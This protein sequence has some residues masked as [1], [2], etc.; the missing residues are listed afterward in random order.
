MKLH[1]KFVLMFGIGTLIA[2][3]GI[4]IALLLSIFAIWSLVPAV[5]VLQTAFTIAFIGGIFYSIGYIGI[6]LT[7]EKQLETIRGPAEVE[8]IL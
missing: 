6:E 4:P 8:R 7:K 2:L 1:E 5:F 3:L